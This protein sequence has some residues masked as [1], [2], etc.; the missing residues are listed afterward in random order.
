MT[1]KNDFMK[2]Y[3]DGKGYLRSAAKG[4]KR[5]AFHA[6]NRPAIKLRIVERIHTLNRSVG[7]NT[8]SI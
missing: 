8:G 2:C 7:T 1:F 4:D 5:E 3:L 6:G